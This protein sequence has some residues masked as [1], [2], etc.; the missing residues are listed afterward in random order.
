MRYLKSWKRAEYYVALENKILDASR[1]PP[2]ADGTMSD[3][4]LDPQVGSSNQAY[5]RNLGTE[6]DRLYQP[7]RGY[8]TY[9]NDCCRDGQIAELYKDWKR[10][11]GHS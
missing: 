9:V 3:P 5:V 7:I 1:P 10:Q 2:Q 8:L 11:H 4:A 6:C